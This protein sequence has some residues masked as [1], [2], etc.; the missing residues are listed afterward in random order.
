MRHQPEDLADALARDSKRF[1]GG[2]LFAVVIMP[3]G[4][5]FHCVPAGESMDAERL[6]R[7]E[8]IEKLIELFGPSAFRTN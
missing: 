4:T 1:F 7:D 6:S 3:D 5:G 2:D 8:M